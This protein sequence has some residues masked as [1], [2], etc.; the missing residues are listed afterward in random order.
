MAVISEII[1]AEADNTL[2]FG[3]YAVVEKQKSNDFKFNGHTYKVKTHNE[4]TRLERDDQMVLETVP[5]TAIHNFADSGEVLEFSAEGMGSTQLTFGLAP[6]TEYN[7]FVDGELVGMA[8][9]SLS[10][11]VSFGAELEPESLFH[12]KIEKV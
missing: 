10:G 8:A 11:K 4:L 3:N 2:S 12:I 7:I 6:E 9:S 1:R 5:G